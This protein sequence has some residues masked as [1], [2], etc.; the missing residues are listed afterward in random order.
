MKIFRLCLV[1]LSLNCARK[2]MPSVRVKGFECG[3]NPE[4]RWYHGAFRPDNIRAFF[5]IIKRSF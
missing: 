2:G 4:V 1:K 5:Y 3:S